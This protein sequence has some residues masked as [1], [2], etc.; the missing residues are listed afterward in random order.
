MFVQFAAQVISLNNFSQY[1]EH[2]NI[3]IPLFSGDELL[4]YS[5][6]YNY[7][8]IFCSVEMINESPTSG[9]Y[10][11]TTMWYYLC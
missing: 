9:K 4:L 8:I 10:I 2:M 1:M 6:K 11:G 3:W 7:E 5:E